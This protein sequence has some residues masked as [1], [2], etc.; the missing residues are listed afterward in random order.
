MVRCHFITIIYIHYSINEGFL[1]EMGAV[2]LNNNTGLTRI[3]ED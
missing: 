3:P 1:Q 2:R